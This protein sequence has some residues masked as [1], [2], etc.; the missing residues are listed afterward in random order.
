MGHIIEEEDDVEKARENQIVIC[1][2]AFYD[3]NHF[4]EYWKKWRQIILS[5]GEESRLREIFGDDEIPSDFD[6]K[7]VDLSEMIFK[8]LQLIQKKFGRLRR[9]VKII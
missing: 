8:K 4:S 7:K 5:R 3:F 6:F 2:T 9:P 1:G